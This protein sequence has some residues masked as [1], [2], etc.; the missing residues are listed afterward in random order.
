MQISWPDSR[1]QAAP[2]QESRMS[3]KA[4]ATRAAHVSPWLDG[5]S[6]YGQAN[7]SGEPPGMQSLA[8]EQPAVP[9]RSIGD[10]NFWTPLPRQPRLRRGLHRD[11]PGL[12]GR[13]A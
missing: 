4:R 13:T 6:R 12:D 3:P 10:E 8:A 2:G 1:R 5:E 7:L 9:M 11:A